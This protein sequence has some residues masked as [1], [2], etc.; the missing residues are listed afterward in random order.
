[1]FPTFPKLSFLTSIAASCISADIMDDFTTG[2]A[3]RLIAG[4]F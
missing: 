2:F 4:L 1:M 3:E